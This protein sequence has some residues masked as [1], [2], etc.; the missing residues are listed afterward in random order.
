MNDKWKKQN[1]H[2]FQTYFLIENSRVLTKTHKS[3]KYSVGWP[4]IRYKYTEINS[5]KQVQ[6][7]ASNTII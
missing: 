6:I 2:F 4:D 3:S 7:L 5:R 1:G